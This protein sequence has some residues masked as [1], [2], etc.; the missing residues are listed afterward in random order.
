MRRLVALAGVALA[1]CSP[2]HADEGTR[3]TSASA[4]TAGTAPSSGSSAAPPTNPPGAS[5]PAGSTGASAPPPDA[6]FTPRKV[7]L[8]EPAMGTEVHFVAYTTRELGESAIHTAMERALGEIRRIEGVMTSWRDSSEVGQINANAGNPVTVS[9]ETITVLQKARWASEL[10]GGVFDITF[11]ALGDLW[12][13]GDAADAEP[14][15]PDPK[16]VRQKKKLVDYRKVL[17]DAGTHTVTVGKGMR[18]DLGGIAKGY[19]VDRAANILKAA[20]LRSFLAQAGG[21][22]YGAGTKPDGTSWVSG[23]QDP[24]AP[25]GQFFAVIELRDHAFSTAGDYARA[26]FV[27]GKRYHHIIDPRTGYPATACRSV[28]VWAGDAFTADAIDDAVFILGPERGLALIDAQP[29][30]GAVI[31]DK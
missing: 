17:I 26:F 11:H 2:R 16:L 6:P 18:I 19:A 15:L 20:G 9:D 24:R 21:D 28:T 10:S 1:A 25:E 5:A 8:I 3:P 29:D 31:V 27:K 12:K 22:L 23:I 13:F 4:L 7:D 14:K 30:A